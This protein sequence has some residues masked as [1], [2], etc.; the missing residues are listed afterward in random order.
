MGLK[1]QLY[2]NIY[3][4]DERADLPKGMELLAEETLSYEISVKENQNIKNL[5]A[6]TPYYWRTSLDDAKKL[7]NLEELQTQI[8]IIFSIFKKKV[9][10]KEDG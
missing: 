5:F 8:D 1:Q 7:D 3:E 4:N 2:D 10:G 9:D 6:M